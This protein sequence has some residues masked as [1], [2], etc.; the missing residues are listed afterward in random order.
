MRRGPDWHGWFFFSS[1]FFSLP[2]A[3]NVT[4]WAPEQALAR[5]VFSFLF[6]SS[7]FF[8]GR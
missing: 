1:P 8:W 3:V 6:F 5:A 2:S 4:E 7:L